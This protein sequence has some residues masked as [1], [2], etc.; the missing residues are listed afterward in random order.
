[1]E[2]KKETLVEDILK[3]LDL[4]TPAASAGSVPDSDDLDSLLSDLLGKPDEQKP[5]EKPEAIPAREVLPDVMQPEEKFV[6]H[7][8]DDDIPPVAPSS[9]FEDMMEETSDFAD[10]F[11]V[12]PAAFENLPE[13]EDPNAPEYRE[14]EEREEVLGMLKQRSYRGFFRSAVLLVLLAFSLL[15][16]FCKRMPD[17]L[18]DLFSPTEGGFG[19]LLLTGIPLVFAMV[20]GFPMIASGFVGLFKK[21][22]NR[23]TLPALT[24][25][26]SL[27]QLLVG[28]LDPNAA[29]RVDLHFYAPIAV[30]GLFFASLGA[31]M[32]NRRMLRQF[33]FI[34]A[35]APRYATLQV[36]D[37]GAAIDITRGMLPDELPAVAYRKKADFFEGFL[38]MTDA[39]DAADRSGSVASPLVLDFC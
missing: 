39:A 27:I 3:E 17:L 28:A 35:D 36:T 30:A 5:A 16:A 25:V 12:D 15:I 20:V 19:Y 26:I 4:D 11:A 6:V 38:S 2:Q 14:P 24:S 8:P 21:H 31:F 22:G 7:L 23:Y 34:T 29:G 32:H 10:P 9:S 33:K 13:E 1:M 18:P 37:K